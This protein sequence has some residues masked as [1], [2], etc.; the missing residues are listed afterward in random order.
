MTTGQPN[1]FKCAIKADNEM[2]RY[3]PIVLFS[4]EWK[5]KWIKYKK[6]KRLPNEKDDERNET[7]YVYVVFVS[8]SYFN[9]N[10]NNWYLPVISHSGGA[11]WNTCKK[12]THAETHTQK[13][14]FIFSILGCFYGIEFE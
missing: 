10:N 1:G 9:R 14:Q 4:G 11:L 3:E 5:K 7:E 8:V 12:S 6:V 2:N 13:T